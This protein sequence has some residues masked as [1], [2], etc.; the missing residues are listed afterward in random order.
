MGNKYF[1]GVASLLLIII[2]LSIPVNQVY[3]HPLDYYAWT[4]ES[5]TT[6]LRVQRFRSANMYASD[7]SAVWRDWNDISPNIRLVALGS[8]TA[9]PEELG[10]EIEIKGKELSG[11]TMAQTS[12]YTKDSQGNWTPELSLFFTGE[13]QK[14]VIWLDTRSSGLYARTDAEQRKTIT[15]ELGHALA[16]AHPTCGNA[17]LMIQGYTPPATLTIQW[18][19]EVNLQFKWD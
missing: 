14:A 11:T 1:L 16:L 12:I 2:L 5:D 7:I 19:D 8:T 10:Y 17:A 4:W 13:I 6:Q 18:H 9:T 3:G 15:H